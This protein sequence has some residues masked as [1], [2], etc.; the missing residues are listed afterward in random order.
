MLLPGSKQWCSG[1]AGDGAPRT[2]A[3]AR[4][5]VMASALRRTVS[6]GGPRWATPILRLRWSRARSGRGKT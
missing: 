1:E 5:G 2:A 6:A 3:G 4:V